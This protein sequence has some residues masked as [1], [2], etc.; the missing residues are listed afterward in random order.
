MKGSSPG[1]S[2]LLLTVAICLTLLMVG[3]STFASASASLLD[4]IKHRGKIIVGVQ[5]SAPPAS[6]V[7]EKGEIVGF[8]VDLAKAI[9]EK[10]GV[11]VE[12]KQ[13]TD[14]TRI[15]SILQGSTDI[16]IATMTHTRE[17]DKVVDF[18]ITYFVTGQRILVP[19][20]SHIKGITDLAG[21]KVGVPRGSTSE[22]N[23][24]RKQPKARILAFDDIPTAFLALQQGAV[25][26]ISSDE[27]V[28]LSTKANAKDPN[29][30]KVVGEYFSSEPF[31]IAMRENDSKLRDFINNAL[32]ELWQS[33]EFK[34]IY[35]KWYG[36]GTKYE[37]PLNFEMEVWP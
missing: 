10:L 26:A 22:Q 18:S 28:L 29:A 19:K 6:M 13:L 3:F 31:G 27:S 34:K 17:R 32:I 20:N 1:K 24:A 12:F 30:W 36:P 21:K 9:A 37:L 15:P 8:E 2:W 4:T 35:D 23:V 5:T 7:N 33:G 11:K 16:V 14:A 25:D